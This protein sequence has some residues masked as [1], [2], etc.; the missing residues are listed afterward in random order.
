M[1]IPYGKQDV[2]DADIDA[3]I[4]VLRSDFLTQ[5]EMVPKFEHELSTESDAIIYIR[6]D[7]KLK[8]EF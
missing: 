7:A 3:V 4:K 8:A 5:G 1:N 6:T 2:T